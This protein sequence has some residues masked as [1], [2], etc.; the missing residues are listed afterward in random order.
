MGPEPAED[1]APA[2]S[3]RRIL[4]KIA[5]TS[6][7]ARDGSTLADPTVVD[8]LCQQPHEPP[9][10]DGPALYGCE[11]AARVINCRGMLANQTSAMTGR[12]S[13]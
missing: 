5:P 6:T 9:S 1:P 10:G 3:L 7:P 11:P 4:R 8:D 12:T 13:P 2:R